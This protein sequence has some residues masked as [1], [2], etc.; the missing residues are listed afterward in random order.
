MSN[1]INPNFFGSFIPEEMP[2]SR[3]QKES[4][5]MKSVMGGNFGAKFTFTIGTTYMGFALMGLLHGIFFAKKPSFAL[6]T[7]RLLFSYY[8]NSV[9]HNSIR[10]ANNASGATM[11]YCGLGWGLTKAFEDEMA[12][13]SPFETNILIG[14]LSGGI[15]KS[16]LGF[17]PMGIGALSG[18]ALAG[19]INYIIDELRERDYIGFEM[20]FN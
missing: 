20:R 6:P 13:F 5:I 18:M 19:G 11:I 4:V 3:T 16:T 12:I 1:T 8:L 14:F 7:K 9:S 2:P 17:G 15:Y 10:F